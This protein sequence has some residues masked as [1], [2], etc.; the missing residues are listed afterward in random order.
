G[1]GAARAGHLRAALLLGVYGLVVGGG[2]LAPDVGVL[3]GM[4]VPTKVWTERARQ[5]QR[6]HPQPR[7]AGRGGVR[8]AVGRVGAEHLGGAGRN[9]R[10]CPS[11]T[12]RNSTIHGHG[13]GGSVSNSIPPD[14]DGMGVERWSSSSEPSTRQASSDA[15]KVPEVLIT[16]RSPGE[17]KLGRSG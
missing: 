8:T 5:R 12:R 3:D 2:P 6:N 10:R 13:W 9:G 17:R 4:A 1:E 14:P 11:T 15:G 7:L 16:S